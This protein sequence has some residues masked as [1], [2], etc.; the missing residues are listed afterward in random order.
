[1]ADT[2]NRIIKRVAAG[3]SSGSNLLQADRALAAAT[4][5]ILASNA[6]HL[7][8]ESAYRT[9]RTHAGF[10]GFWAGSPGDPSTSLGPEV[11]DIDWEGT[12]YETA[13]RTANACLGTHWIVP[14]G[15][16][17]AYPKAVLRGRAR[18][19]SDGS[20]AIGV[21]FGVA[22]GVGAFPSATSTFDRV[23]ITSTSFVN[24]ELEIALTENDL[25][26]HATT[27]TAGRSASGVSTVTEAV[28]V[29]AATFWVGAYNSANKNS[30][31]S[32]VADLLGLTLTLEPR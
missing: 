8:A 28:R 1:M 10:L 24:V 19:P 4:G 12:G 25:A 6:N 26:P 9:L 27:P 11:D 7:G 15:A 20:Y 30:D 5:H 13:G 29:M 18:A 31:P 3:T 21:Y 2:L 23:H 17:L 22:P 14:V 16:T 32:E